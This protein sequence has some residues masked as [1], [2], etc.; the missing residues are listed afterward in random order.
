MKKIIIIFLFLIS[1]IFTAQVG[2]G[3]IPDASAQLDV[4]ATN[5]GIVIPRVSLN[6]VNDNSLD[7]GNTTAIEGLTIY[8]TN[9]NV[10]GGNGKGF[11][12]YNGTKWTKLIPQSDNIAVVP[13]DTGT[14]TLTSTSGMDIPGYDSAF[15]PIFFNKD[16]NLQIKLIIRYS[17]IQGDVKFQLRAHDDVAESYPIVFSDFGV[18]GHTQNGGVATS[19]W[20]NWN[21]GTHAHEIHLF[22][23]IQSGN[24]GDHVTI[25]SAYLLVRSQ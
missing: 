1:Q 6:D 12:Y 25:E 3:G 10:T 24:T 2:I 4:S 20:K 8:N 5:K 17:S 13:I 21:A 16:G 9:D 14:Y 22:A 19:D 18:F 23:W 11:Y 7:S 15:E